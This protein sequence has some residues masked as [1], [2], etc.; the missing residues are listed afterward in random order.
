M[1]KKMNLCTSTHKVD[2]ILDKKGWDS[3]ND[4][5]R[6]WKATLSKMLLLSSN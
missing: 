3:Y 6:C 1:N 5:N 4:M 2:L